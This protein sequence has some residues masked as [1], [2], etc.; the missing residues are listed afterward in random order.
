[1]NL[2][3]GLQ[4]T[5]SNDPLQKVSIERLVEAIRRPKVEFQQQI[6]RLRMIR[7]LDP[8]QYSRLKRELPYFVCGHFHPPIRRREHFSSI[9]HLIIDL[10]HFQWAELEQSQ[11]AD[12]LKNDDRVMLL[13]ASPGGDGLKVLFQLD[14]P[15]FDYGLF[16]LFYKAFVQKLAQQYALEKV[17]DTSTHDVTRACFLSCDPN[18]FYRPNAS[19]LIMGHY[20]DPADP[21]AE[22]DIKKSQKELV[23]IQAPLPPAEKT[24]NALS[25]EVLLDIKRKLNP[26][27]KP[28]PKKPDPH[29]PAELESAMP[30]IAE[31][32]QAVEAHI[33]QNTPIQYGKCIR[34]GMGDYWA[35]V[36]VFFGKRGFSV[37][38]TTKTGSQP[39]L[40]E[41]AYQLIYQCLNPD[42]HGPTS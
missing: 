2:Q 34:I 6:E 14:A 11:V 33:L 21:Q 39:Q 22:Q 3:F 20:F 13:F 27:F 36:N 16:S 12:Q 37:V 25:N 15:C 23:S 35:E 26:D 31:A 17:V 30:R 29:V 38:K 5:Q 32:L 40:A 41:L 9:Q 10:D 8:R 7:A 4:I 42:Y 19:P 24:N 28:R 18:A 1:M